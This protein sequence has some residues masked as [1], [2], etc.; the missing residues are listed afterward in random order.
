MAQPKKPFK[1]MNTKICI[2]CKSNKV[3]KKG[4]SH[5][6]QRWKCKDYHKIFQANRKALPDKE[7]LFYSFSFHKQTLHTLDMG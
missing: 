6:I 4:L 3:I 7:E 1:R 5:N 2:H